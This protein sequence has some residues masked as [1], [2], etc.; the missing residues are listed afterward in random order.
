MTLLAGA[1]APRGTVVARTA[2][3]LASVRC[4]VDALAPAWDELAERTGASPFTRPGWVLPWFRAFGRG[5]LELH[6]VRRGGRLVAVLPLARRA[7]ALVSPTNFHT[8]HFGPVAQDDDARAALAQGVLTQRAWAVSLGFLESGAGHLGA[9]TSEAAAARRRT[10]TRTVLRSPSVE[11]SGDLAGYRAH[12]RRSALADLRRRRRRLAERGEVRMRRVSDGPGASAVLRH[13]LELE[14]LGWKG[15]RGT[16]VAQAPAVHRFYEHVAAW[17]AGRG[18]LSL[19]Q[20]SL[21]ERPIAFYFGVEHERTLH[22]LKGAYDPGLAR[23]S[24]GQLLLED[25]VADGFARG[26]AR[27]ELGGSPE[28]YKLVWTGD[29]RERLRVTAFAPG[30][31][32]RAGRLVTVH[33]RPLAG[34]AVRGARRRINGQG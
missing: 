18:W 30:A 22:L 3:A 6:M 16:A 15:E 26:L 19:Y 21:D 14:R 13:G 24:P 33:G 25:V 5:R 9:F 31:A 17:A 34:R 12:R 1:P 28:R 10:V 2:P 32:G 8:P 11:L 27:I 20:L 7:G 29:V 23:L 4:D